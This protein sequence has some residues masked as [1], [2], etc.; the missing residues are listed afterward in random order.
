MQNTLIRT[1][2]KL[3][4]TIYYVEHQVSILGSKIAVTSWKYLHSIGGIE[5]PV[6]LLWT[7]GDANLSL[8]CDERIYTLDKLDEAQCAVRLN[9]SKELFMREGCPLTFRWRSMCM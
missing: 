9:L 7:S 6:G 3:H 2:F 1:I 5:C 8:V 4:I